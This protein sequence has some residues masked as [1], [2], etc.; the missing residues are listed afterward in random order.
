MSVPYGNGRGSSGGAT[1][2][3]SGGEPQPVSTGGGGGSN[4]GGNG[5]PQGVSSSGP[6]GGNEQ[7]PPAP[8]TKIPLGGNGGS[9]GGLT[10]AQRAALAPVPTSTNVN[11]VPVIVPASGSSVAIGGQLVSIPP[12]GSSSEVVANGQTF[13]VRGSEIVGP[14]ATVRIAAE[15][16][17]L[18]PGAP[19][20]V[21][22]GRLTF[23]VG[24]SSAIID[25]STYKIGSGAPSSTLTISGQ[26]VIVGPSGVAV[27][28][29]TLVPVKVTGAGPG[30]SAVTA[31]GL[32]FS[33]GTSQVVIGGSTYKIGSGAPTETEVV[34]GKTI[35]IGPSGIGLGSSVIPPATIPLSTISAGGLTFAVG[36]TQV[37]V[38][39]ST[40]KIGSGAPTETE[41]INGKTVS[42]GPSGIGLA[43]TTVAPEATGSN[44]QAQTGTAAFS[45]ALSACTLLALTFVFGLHL[46]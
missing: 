40:Y 12:S 11:G 32:T 14:S 15:G 18:A 44:G 8:T 45:R 1:S 6:G 4:G 28:G 36:P 39:G 30:L 21:T 46:L 10:S 26:T 17:A 41:V 20:P 38:G 25:G 31:A 27:P 24:A 43:S 7:A 42:I 23:S 34:S 2:K 19:T 16:S 9:G 22:A 5:S 35:S 29:T 37:V 13:T 3:A 33:I